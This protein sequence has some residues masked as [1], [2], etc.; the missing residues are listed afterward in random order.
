M[1]TTS[2]ADNIL[3]NSTPLST[4]GNAIQN[5]SSTTTV[6]LLRN[7]TND[8]RNTLLDADDDNPGRLS[9]HGYLATGIYLTLLGLFAFFGNIMMLVV[10]Y[11]GNTHFTRFH[12]MMLTNIA[13][14]DMGVACTAYPYTAISGYFRK[15][16]FN[17]EICVVAGFMTY[18]FCTS[19][20]NTLAVIAFSRY[21]TVCKKEWGYLIR[22]SSNKWFLI[23]IWVYTLFWTGT[24]LIGWSNY[25]YEPFGTSCSLNWFGKRMVDRTYNSLCCFFCFGVHIIIFVFCYAK[26]SRNY[27][28]LLKYEEPS[29]RS[30]SI[31]DITLEETVQRRKEILLTRNMTKKGIA[32]RLPVLEVGTKNYQ[33]SD[34]TRSTK[35]WYYM[36]TR[37]DIVKLSRQALQSDLQALALHSFY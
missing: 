34:S 19:D 13:I 21:V 27:N 22:G 28:K 8:F 33:P 24:P 20:M 29:L 15:W 5:V 7:V 35:Q 6:F 11:K 2:R 30:V 25:T 26:I 9:S 23:G 32:R 14:C 17:D 3:Q 4:I 12:T 10:L 31:D 36:F 37:Y 16:I 18:T 1:T